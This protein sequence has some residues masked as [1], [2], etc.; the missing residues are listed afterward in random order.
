MSLIIHRTTYVALHLT[1][2]N[3]SQV[4]PIRDASCCPAFIIRITGPYICIAGT[5]F[6]DRFISQPL[7]EYI[8]VGGK[9][10]ISKRIYEIARLFSVLKD[11][12]ADLELYYSSLLP[13]PDSRTGDAASFPHFRKFTSCLDNAEIE[14]EY[15]E[16]LDPY[17]PSKA[18]FKALAR[19][20]AG[21][22][23]RTVLVIVKFTNTYGRKGHELLAARSF[24]PT[25]WF[26]EKVESVG[27][28][29]VV[30]MDFVEGS[31]LDG[32]DILGL[33]AARVLEQAVKELHDN[34]LVFGDLRAPNIILLDSNLNSEDIAG[35]HSEPTPTTTLMLVDFDWCNEEGQ[36][37]YPADINLDADMGWHADVECG[38]RIRQEQ[39]LHMLDQ[40]AKRRVQNTTRG[41]MTCADDRKYSV[42]SR[43]GVNV[44]R[45]YLTFKMLQNR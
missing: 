32:N 2:T 19:N 1:L 12:L 22:R 8:Y 13:A 41:K 37:K 21:E 7:T 31:S 25:L 5:V 42:A 16:R 34:G 40:L 3:T 38:G 4:A 17:H 15:I 45:L 14:L 44:M 29:Y 30:V 35:P 20:L 27:G 11:C 39:D 9:P 26:C 23:S 43:V 36:A 6:A 18:V 24:A 28:S 10:D 33:G